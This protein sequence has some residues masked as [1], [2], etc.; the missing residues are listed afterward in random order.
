MS[1]TTDLGAQ[2][3]VNG[4]WI[5]GAGQPYEVINPATED[6]LATVA[7]VSVAQAADA[8]GAAREAF[9]RAPGAGPP[10]R[11]GPGCFTVWPIS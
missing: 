5:D 8:V 4:R 11:N 9:E 3:Y 6:I 2:A 1:V 7:P 10:P